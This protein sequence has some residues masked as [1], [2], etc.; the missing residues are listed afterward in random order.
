M[1]IILLIIISW[2]LTNS[3]TEEWFSLIL[4]SHVVEVI[5]SAVTAK[6]RLV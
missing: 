4:I 2:G 3:V 1:I 5:P 6:G